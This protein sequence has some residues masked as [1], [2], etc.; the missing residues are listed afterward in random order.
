MDNCFFRVSNRQHLYLTFFAYSGPNQYNTT[1][2]LQYILTYIIIASAASISLYHLY[3]MLIPKK[4]ANKC[5][6]CSGCDLSKT[7]NNQNCH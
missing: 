6:G 2:M 3:K 4:A 5:H 1:I 7:H